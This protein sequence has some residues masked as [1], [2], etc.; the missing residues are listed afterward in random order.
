[1]ISYPKCVIINN[2]RYDI[3]TDFKVALRCQEVAENEDIGDTERAM[4][5][6][7]LLFGEK[8]L[9]SDCCDEL[10]LKAKK[11]LSCGKELP[12]NNEK[13]DMDFI[14]DYSYIKASFRSDYNINIDK[15]EMH[16]WEF[17]DL[18]NGLSNSEMGNCC[19]LNRI[20]NIRNYDLSK[21]DDLKERQKMKEAKEQVALKRNKPKKP[22]A[23]E[24]QKQRALQ[25]Y[26][27]LNN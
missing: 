14:E 5:I 19:I 23:T 3:N 24:E 21:L 9:N 22:K 11:Y 1:M 2:E 13:P 16:W 4:A 25:F 27:S 8:G 20:R 15:E 10:L 26:K 6:I 17:F 12:K 7:Y 18:L